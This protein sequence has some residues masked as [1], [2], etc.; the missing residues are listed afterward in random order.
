[1]CDLSFFVVEVE[2]DEEDGEDFTLEGATT[3]LTA[4]RCV[5]ILSI[6]RDEADAYGSSLML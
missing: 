4:F 2:K 6:V 1:M 5:F 3:E